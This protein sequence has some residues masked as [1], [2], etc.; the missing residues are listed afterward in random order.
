MARGYGST[1][2]FVPRSS[3]SRLG[4]NWV[5]KM[6]GLDLGFSFF[7]FLRDIT[8]VCYVL[9]LRLLCHTLTF[10]VSLD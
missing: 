10:L 1:A 8:S 6:A 9:D 7:Q 3:C 4:R 2:A 5:K